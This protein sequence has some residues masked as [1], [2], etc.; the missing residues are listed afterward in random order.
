MANNSKAIF[1][2]LGAVFLF[3]VMDAA[4]K[5]LTQKIG[6]IPTIWARYVGQVIIVF[7]ILAPRL[8]KVGKTNYPKLQATRSVLLMGATSCFL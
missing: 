2:I 5:H 3:T 4:A 8:S 1:F 6:I 7:A